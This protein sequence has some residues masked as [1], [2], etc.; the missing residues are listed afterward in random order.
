MSSL[1]PPP[2]PPHLAAALAK[3]AGRPADGGAVRRRMPLFLAALPALQ[4]ELV[5]ITG[6]NGKGS[7]CAM[8][9][10]V[11]RG[12]GVPVG[13]FTSPHLWA[14]EE[15]VRV[16]GANVAPMVLDAHVA[17][18]EAALAPVCAREGVAPSFFELLLLAA[19]R[20]FA[21]AGV[22]LAILEAGIGGAG[23]A[24]G[25]LPAALSAITSIGLDHCATLG[26]TRVE[27]AREKAGIAHETLVVSPQVEADA[28]AA[29]VEASAR[30]GV[31]VV[32]APGLPPALD[33][34]L[35]GSRVDVGG[36]IVDL[37]LCGP[38]QLANLATVRALVEQ[39]VRSGVFHDA[40]VLAGV[41]T[42]RWPGRLEWVP[43]RW[44]FD[45][46]H[47]PEGLSALSEALDTHVPPAE[48]VVVYGCAEGKDLAAAAPLVGALGG[49]LF[50]VGGFYR[51]V[52]RARLEAAFPGVPY[53]GTPAEARRALDGE[54]GTFIV[55]GS[56][57][58][59]GEFRA[60]FL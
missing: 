41:A 42:T 7:T 36:L 40:T 58:L 19:L 24:T 28:R 47:N 32:H 60:G 4:M 52:D 21:E 15:R 38:H 25:Q 10:A 54:P 59:V 6:T 12:A 39:L 11:A 55:T 22:K 49:R 35:W 33:A 46:A 13:M 29:I 57:F 34:G 1:V 44:V 30:R 37:P 5:T 14:I 53:L 43:P 9:E 51:S 17:A 27:I 56:V 18:I 2:W 3:T 16:N 23:D 31:T 26:A 45:V 20:I 50:L 48:R 8:L